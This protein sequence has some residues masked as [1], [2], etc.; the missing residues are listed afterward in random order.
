MFPNFN[1]YYIVIT[2][3]EVKLLII[4]HLLQ[5]YCIFNKKLHTLY[6]VRQS[7]REETSRIFLVLLTC[8]VGVGDRKMRCRILRNFWWDKFP[9][10][11]NKELAC[12][13]DSRLSFKKIGKNRIDGANSVRENKKCIS[14]GTRSEQRVVARIGEEIHFS[15]L[16]YSEISQHPSSYRLRGYVNSPRSGTWLAEEFYL[17]TT[18]ANGKREEKS[19]ARKTGR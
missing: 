16:S 19:G 7:F 3:H 13:E 17:T 5:I 1:E 10:R 18:L 2:S 14:W 4:L 8:T 9:S 6:R 11:I 12:Q 15:C